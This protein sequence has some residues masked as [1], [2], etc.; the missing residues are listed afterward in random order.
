MLKIKIY[1]M[2]LTLEA[3]RH[4]PKDRSSALL[5]VGLFL[6]ELNWLQRLL[7]IARNPAG[8]GEAEDRATLALTLMV[9]KLLAGKI[10]EGWL[11]LNGELK[12]DVDA[13]ADD[14]RDQ[15][16]ALED[17]LVKDSLLYKLRNLHAFHYSAQ[18]SLADLE[19]LPVADEELAIYV[20]ESQG[21]TLFHIS[22]LAA[23]GQFMHLTGKH[24]GREA[25][26]MVLDEVI[27]AT[28][29]YGDYLYSVLLYLLGEDL[30]ASLQQHELPHDAVDSK[31]VGPRIS[32]F[33]LPVADAT[34]L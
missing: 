34:D 25:L 2:Q 32:F 29:L 17:C 21:H 10:F 3:L 19:S 28:M 15:R 24:D 18:I 31:A 33:E 20:T 27:K 22:E 4:L 14:V 1:K 9:T 23:I 13:L 16:E 11:K 30:L 6:N 8:A 7:L 12:I 5:R 26:E